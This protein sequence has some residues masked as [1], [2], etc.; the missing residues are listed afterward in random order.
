MRLTFPNGEHPSLLL[1]EGEIGIGAAAHHRVCLPY[2]GLRADH[3]RIRRDRL[4]CWLSV[5]EGAE[6]VH[7]NARP[8]REL[9]MLRAGDVL[10][11]GSVELL[12]QADTE[13]DPVIPVAAPPLGG[14]EPA[15]AVLRG[16]GGPHFG[17]A[18]PF[19]SVLTL[20]RA[21]SSGVRLDGGFAERHLQLEVHEEGIALRGVAGTGFLVNGHPVRDCR[22]SRGDQ[23]CLDPYR[24][25]LEVP[26]DGK[27]VLAMEPA[28]AGRVA[29]AREP[30]ADAGRRGTAVWWLIGAAL[31]VATIITGLLLY[32]PGT[33]R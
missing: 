33:S 8:V 19:S 11:L 13:P 17:R 12:L 25:V 10:F 32:G 28:V 22:L 6:N 5:G 1:K 15:R 27:P 26:G 24:F 18:F 3:A 2:A 14:Q 30:V 16:V 4:G 9:A 21:E 29:E 20:G 23:L 7:L 31:L